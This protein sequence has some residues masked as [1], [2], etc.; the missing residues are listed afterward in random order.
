MHTRKRLLVRASLL[1]LAAPIALA[2]TA[3]AADD[4]AAKAQRR[5]AIVDQLRALQQELQTLDAAPADA[6]AAPAR[7]VALSAADILVTAVRPQPTDKPLGQ[8]VSSVDE[9]FLATVRGASVTELMQSLPGVTVQQNNGPR[10]SSI[11]IRGSR[12]RSAM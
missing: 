8:T 7:P 6:G 5:A 2:G 1:A 12:S 10:D 4:T 9:S 3:S 11:S